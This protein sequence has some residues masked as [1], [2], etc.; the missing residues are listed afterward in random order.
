MASRNLRDALMSLLIGVPLAVLGSAIAYNDPL[1]GIHAT[2]HKYLHNKGAA[3]YFSIKVVSGIT[4]SRRDDIVSLVYA[5]IKC[6]LG[7]LPWEDE[8]DTDDI[9]LQKWAIDTDEICK[10]LPPVF[11][12]ILWH[13][14]MMVYTQQL[15]YE[16]WKQ[17]F[18]CCRSR[19]GFP[20]GG[21]IWEH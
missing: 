15:E 4:P 8:V 12:R 21:L 3:V 18:W 13:A 9:L 7:E 1:T 6:A 10:G 5:L 11:G 19:L 16:I 20:E 14:Q 17:G 2:R